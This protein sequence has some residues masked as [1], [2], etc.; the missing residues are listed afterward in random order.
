MESCMRMAR[1]ACNA[2]HFCNTT[3]RTFKGTWQWGGFSVFF[4]EIGS[5]WVPFEPFLFWLR[6]RRDIHNRK[7]TPRYHRYGESPTPRISDTGSCQLP[8]RVGY[9]FFQRELSIDDMESR[10]LPTPVIRW[11]ADSP[12]RWVGESPT[13]GITDMESR[14]LRVSLSRGV[15]RWYG[16][17]PFKE[18]LIWCRFSELLTVNHAF[19]GPIWQKI[20]QGCNLLS[21]LNYLKVSK[22]WIL[23]AI[24]SK[25][26]CTSLTMESRF[27]TRST[28]VAIL[29]LLH[30]EKCQ[31]L[32]GM[33]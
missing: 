33:V 18:I 21:Q 22:K 11:V 12:Y 1:I 6:I 15:D 23:Q 29:I 14:Q 10:R 2:D 24:L 20:S 4:A 5:S 7:T 17:S 27:K 13:P 9:K 28:I 19:K 31:V 26:T 3:A 16:K 8:A 32:A 25:S 30:K